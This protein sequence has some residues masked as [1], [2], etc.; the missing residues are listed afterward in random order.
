MVAFHLLVLPL[1]LWEDPSQL[2]NLGPLW[3]MV[4]H[5]TGM[6]CIL[7]GSHCCLLPTV[8]DAFNALWT[9]TK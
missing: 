4:Q 9:T 6:E 7:V 5:A 3:L 1:P 2:P 8:W